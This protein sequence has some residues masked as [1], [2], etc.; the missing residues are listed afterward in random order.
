MKVVRHFGRSLNPYLIYETKHQESM[1]N[2]DR[3]D[4]R[5]NNYLT[6]PIDVYPTPS[7]TMNYQKEKKEYEKVMKKYKKQKSR[8][9]TK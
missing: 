3:T 5:Y 9:C 8:P 2:S 4:I 7:D 1:T 6:D